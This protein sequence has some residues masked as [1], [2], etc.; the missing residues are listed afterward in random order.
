MTIQGET[1]DNSQT[2]SFSFYIAYITC[3]VIVIKN[4]LFMSEI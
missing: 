4:D 3:I 2:E 1:N